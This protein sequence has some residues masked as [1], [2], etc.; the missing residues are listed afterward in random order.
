MCG[1]FVVFEKLQTDYQR[2]QDIE[3]RCSTRRLPLMARKVRELAKERGSLA[4]ICLGH[5]ALPRT[6]PAD[7]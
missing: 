7:R 3:R 2:F 5:A 4:K 6:Q 1:D